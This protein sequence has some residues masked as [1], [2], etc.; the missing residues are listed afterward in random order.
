MYRINRIDEIMEGMEMIEVDIEMI[1]NGRYKRIPKNIKR[2]I[3]EGEIYKYGE[4]Y[5][6]IEYIRLYDNKI[7]KKLIEDGYISKEEYKYV[8]KK[9]IEDNKNREEIIEMII[10]R[11]EIR[12]IGEYREHISED[13]EILIMI[14]R[15]G[16]RKE[17]ISKMISKTYYEVINRIEEGKNTIIDEVIESVEDEILTYV[18]DIF[19]ERV[20]NNRKDTLYRICINEKEIFGMNIIERFNKDNYDYIDEDNRSVLDIICINHLDMLGLKILRYLNKEIINKTDKEG[21]SILDLIVEHKLV[22]MMLEIMPYM[23]KEIIKRKRYGIE[24][25]YNILHEI[26]QSNRLKNMIAE[27]EKYF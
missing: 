19:D 25:K 22:F 11:V 4:E 10:E 5:K 27:I 20:I 1:K 21:D 13:N 18:R 14:L 3:C 2:I 24:G 9:M 12:E 6:D 26:R 8:I 7:I 23:N 16:M 17:I 15:K